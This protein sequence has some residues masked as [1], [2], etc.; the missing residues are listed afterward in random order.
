MIICTLRND[1][2]EYVS[3][4]GDKTTDWFQASKFP[5]EDAKKRLRY[6]DKEFEIVRFYM[7]E[8]Q[9]GQIILPLSGTV[10]LIETIEKEEEEK[11]TPYF[12]GYKPQQY[13]NI[14]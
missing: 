7:W 4:S 8:K 6:V 3:M 9:G 12:K 14:K 13:F 10:S 1:K 2:G 5:E 11:N